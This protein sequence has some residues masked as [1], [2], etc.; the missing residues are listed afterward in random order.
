MEGEE[1]GPTLSVTVGHADAPPASAKIYP[2]SEDPWVQ[3]LLCYSTSCDH[4]PFT[5]ESQFPPL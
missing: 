2:L 4:W 3:T 1:E 5:S